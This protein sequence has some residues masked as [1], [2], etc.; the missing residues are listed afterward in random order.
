MAPA[1]LED[2]LLAHPKVEDV[3]GCD[4]RTGRVR[5]RKFRPKDYFVLKDGID[6]GGGDLGREIDRV[7]TLKGRKVENEVDYVLR[8]NFVG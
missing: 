8:L 3:G 6:E 4:E 2:L 5:G 7:C 1:E